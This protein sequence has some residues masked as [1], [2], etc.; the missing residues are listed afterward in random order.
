MLHYHLQTAR[1]VKASWCSSGTGSWHSVRLQTVLVKNSGSRFFGSTGR[2][3][4][5][6]VQKGLHCWGLGPAKAAKSSDRLLEV[7]GPVTPQILKSAGPDVPVT[8]TRS[9]CTLFTFSLRPP[10]RNFP[11][12]ARRRCG[13]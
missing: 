3:S 2:A 12:D 8:R 10:S 11:P 13:G 7:V 5:T 1:R 9:R 6:T 4:P